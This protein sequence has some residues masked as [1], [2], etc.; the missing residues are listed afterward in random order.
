MTWGMD[1]LLV[2]TKDVHHLNEKT[3]FMVFGII[4]FVLIASNVTSEMAA[5]RWPRN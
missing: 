2:A 5:R 3:A 4:D 1:L